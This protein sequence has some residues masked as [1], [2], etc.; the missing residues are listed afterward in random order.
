MRLIVILCQIMSTKIFYMK[1]L[2]AFFICLLACTTVAC[3]QT[4]VRGQKTVGIQAGYNSCA[5]SGVAGIFFQY[6]F[7]KI[8]RIAPS[9]DYTFR[10]NNIDGYSL[11]LDTHYPI[12]L[13]Q[14]VNFYPIV[15]VCYSSWNKHLDKDKVSDDSDS[16]Y[17]RFGLNLGGGIEVFVSDALKLS[18]EAKYN[19]IRNFDGAVVKA[20]IGYVF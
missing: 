1:K 7:S 19:W 9:I 8:F 10:H 13:A 2:I 5:E 20:S 4:S 11:N 15:G 17:N 14:K 16:R 12:D 6:R 3:A 18:V